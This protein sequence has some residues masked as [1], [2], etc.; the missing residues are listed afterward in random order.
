MNLNK[1]NKNDGATFKRNDDFSIEKLNN[2]PQTGPG[3]R[4]YVSMI[5][6]F[7]RAIIYQSASNENGKVLQINLA[8]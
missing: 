8:G 7:D 1:Q 3:T 2:A 6:Y 4:Y 5:L